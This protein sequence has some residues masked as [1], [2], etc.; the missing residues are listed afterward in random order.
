L[1]YLQHMLWWRRLTAAH[2]APS[3]LDI[4][5]CSAANRAKLLH[6]AEL[7]RAIQDAALEAEEVECKGVSRKQHLKLLWIC[8]LAKLTCPTPTDT[9]GK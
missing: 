5:P 2:P 9:L 3:Q 8:K 1:I 7:H 6:L 4:D